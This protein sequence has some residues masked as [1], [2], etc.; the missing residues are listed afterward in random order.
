MWFVVFSD[1]RL[2][3]SSRRLLLKLVSALST[4]IVKFVFFSADPSGCHRE[5]HLWRPQTIVV[6][7]KLNFYRI[8]YMQT[9]CITSHTALGLCTL[10]NES[11]RKNVAISFSVRFCIFIGTWIGLEKTMSTISNRCLCAATKKSSTK[12]TTTATKPAATP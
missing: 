8:S 10:C 9:I 7:I 6:N 1:F 12:A 3:C 5:A 11:E 2:C 4:T